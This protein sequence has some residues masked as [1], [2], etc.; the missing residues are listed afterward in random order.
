VLGEARSFLVEDDGHAVA[1]D[2]PA[3]AEPPLAVRIA[4]DEAAARGARPQ[5]LHVLVEPGLALPDGALWSERAGVKV[6]VAQGLPPLAAP[7][8]A[9]TIDLLAGDFARRGAGAGSLRLPRLAWALAAALVLLQFGATLADGWRLE[10]E[11][12]ALE[13]EREAIFRAAFPE[14]KTVVDPAL[15]MRRNLADLQRSRGRAAASDFLALASSV[16]KADPAPAKRLVY[17]GGRLEV[18]RAGAKP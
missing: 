9:G 7:A 4:A 15:Q 8:A 14:A 17:A 11:R 5:R 6:S 16:A 1:F 12:R 2:R 10:A 3:G 18:D 13:A